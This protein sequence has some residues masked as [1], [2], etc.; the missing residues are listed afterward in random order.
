VPADVRLA[1]RLVLVAAVLAY[2]LAVLAF[3]GAPDFPSR[4]DCMSPPTGEGELQVVFGY[5][6]SETE[7]LELR[8]K[9]IAVGFSGTE[10]ARDACGR[11]RVAVDDVPSREVGEEVIRE[12]HT[13]GL[14]PH[15]E[16]E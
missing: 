13:V 8:D 15:L 4:A 16:Q 10:I 5:R 7:A 6:D 2:P 12:A 11:V 1:P 3:S 14:D 9:V